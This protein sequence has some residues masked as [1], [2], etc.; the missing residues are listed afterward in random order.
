MKK[1]YIKNVIMIMSGGVGARFGTNCPKQYNKM[2]DRL[3]IDYIV[4][5][6]KRSRSV[7]QIIIVAAENYMDFVQKRFN[8][9]VVAG[10]NTRP[11][12]VAH[13]LQYIHEHYDCEKLII[14]NAVCPLASENQYD[15]YFDLLDEY[16]FVLTTW[17]LAPA[18]HRF[19]EQKVDRDQYFNVMEPDAYRFKILYD[20]YNFVDPP[21]YIFHNMPVTSKRFYCFDY[22]YTTKVTYPFD[23]PALEVLHDLLIEKPRKDKLL[24]N[25]NYYVSSDGTSGVGQWL[26]RVQEDIKEIAQRYR[27]TEYV[28]NSQTQASIVY[29]GY[30]PEY[31]DIIFK[32][33][34]TEY[35]YHKEL[36][37]YRL[38][39]DK[40]MARLI[41]CDDEKYVLTLEKI[42]P[43]IQV[44]FHVDD[45]L[46]NTLYD[47]INKSFVPIELLN[48]DTS[49]PYF[50]DEFRAFSKSADRF[51]FEFSYRKRME[52]KTARIWKKYF[53]NV[54]QYY[55]HGDI[56]RRNILDENGHYR[57][58]DPRGTIAP[59]EFEF[60]IQFITELREDI[61]NQFLQDNYK[62]LLDYFSEY[63]ETER[64]TAALFVFWVHKLNDYI[65]HKNDNFTLAA[66]CKDCIQKLFFNDETDSA[67]DPAIPP[68]GIKW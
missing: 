49:V 25:V 23:I 24:R 38:A 32:F 46:M 6:G 68:M 61:S 40:I 66:W 7:D 20:S 54:P 28:L 57:V 56:Q 11:E 27:V 37:Y 36:T 47:E 4:D 33:D 63:V 30:S 62:K 13:G 39:S 60:V 55:L 19:D 10:G 8:L 9:P 22:P 43:G 50:K 16:D 12:S 35:V 59:K 64:L 44:K 14:T 2:K 5:A 53:E 17:K 41:G 3:V 34:P 65:F 21:K 1:S 45:P 67:M 51:T 18:L 52:E 31:G 42:K 58:I 48:G 29:E 26:D 15:R